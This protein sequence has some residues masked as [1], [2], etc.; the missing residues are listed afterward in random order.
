MGTLY[1]QLHHASIDVSKKRF[2]ALTWFGSCGYHKLK[3]EHHK[4]S[5]LCPICKNELVKVRYFGS[6]VICTDFHSSLFKRELFMDAF[7]DGKPV[8]AVLE[9]EKPN[10]G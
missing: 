7:E 5:D 3:V 8:F 9:D 10:S 4:H 1:Y 6:V 2:H